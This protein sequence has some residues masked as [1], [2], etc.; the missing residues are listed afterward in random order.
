MIKSAGTANGWAIIDTARNTIN[1]SGTILEPNSS[2]AE[3]TYTQ[4]QIDILSNGFKVRSGAYNESNGNGTTYI[5][6]A[7]AENPFKNSLAR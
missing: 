2:N 1:V 4:W 5:Y 6:M 7:F 3:A